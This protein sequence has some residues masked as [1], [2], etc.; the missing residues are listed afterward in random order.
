MIGIG[1]Q[2]DSVPRTA[3]DA[4]ES[5]MDNPPFS[6]RHETPVYQGK[7]TSRIF[8]R[9][10]KALETILSIPL[11][12]PVNLREAP[13]EQG[14]QRIRYTCTCGKRLYGDYEEIE[15][16]AAKEW[17]RVLNS[18]TNSTQSTDSGGPSDSSNGGHV[19]L[20]TALT[21]GIV[22]IF[23]GETRQGSLV[24][25]L[26]KRTLLRLLPRPR[27]RGLA[28]CSYSFVCFLEITVTS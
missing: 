13:L 1:T 17:E 8:R 12:S 19:S 11:P 25:P 3:F 2:P 23:K 5:D 4:R 27:L 6:I 24:Y 16:G 9:T 15:P 21:S 10:F 26:Y 28:F 14:K 18:L 7:E 22:S 20:L